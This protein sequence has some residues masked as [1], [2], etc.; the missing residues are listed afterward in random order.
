[1]FGASPMSVCWVSNKA[2]LRRCGEQTCVCLVFSHFVVSTSARARP[3][4]FCPHPPG[5]PEQFTKQRSK[6]TS[7]GEQTNIARR[8][9][10]ELEQ[11][12]FANERTIAG[13]ALTPTSGGTNG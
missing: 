12:S 1:M 8:S 4:K 10:T 6:Q 2:L 9:T 3:S 5:E 11:A 7:L 13:E